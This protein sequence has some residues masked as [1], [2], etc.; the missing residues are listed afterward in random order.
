MIGLVLAEKIG[1]LEYISENLTKM[2]GVNQNKQAHLYDVWEHSLRTLQHAAD[3]KLELKIR[4]AALFHDIGKPATKREVGNKTTFY[5]HDVVGAKITRETLSDLRF[6][7]EIIE[8]VSNLVRWHMFFSDTEEITASA[9][10]RLIKNVGKENIWNLMELRKCDRVGTGRPK[11][12]PYRL[13]KFEAML[14]EVMSDPVDVSMLKI[15]G[16]VL[17]NDLKIEVGPKIGYILHAL[18]EEVLDNPEKNTDEYLLKRAG[19]MANMEIDVLK[20]L[21]ETGKEAKKEAEEEKI[22]EI[23]SKRGVK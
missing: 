1:I 17:I 23:R 12:E 8:E 7:K 19:E 3:K 15:N 4:L 2:L 13:R 10:R 6:S 20:A 22:K 16:N 9:V 18:L 21:G 5:G 14:E 11:E